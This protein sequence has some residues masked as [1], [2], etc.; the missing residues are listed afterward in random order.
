MAIPVITSLNPSSGLIGSSFNIIGTDLLNDVTL[1]QTPD[2]IWHL[3]GNLIDA[4]G[5]YTL[6]QGSVTYTTGI[7][8]QSAVLDGT[9]ALNS[10]ISVSTFR[11]GGGTNDNSISCWINLTT[12]KDFNTIWQVG[13]DVYGIL[14]GAK[15]EV[16]SSG[17]LVFTNR[18]LDN[19]TGDTTLAINTWYNIVFQS[20]TASASQSFIYINSVVDSNF[21]NFN[22]NPWGNAAGNLTFGGTNVGTNFLEGKMDEIYFFLD[23]KVTSGDASNLFNATSGTAPTIDFDGTAVTATS[24]GPTLLSGITV[25]GLTFD[26]HPVTT[27]NTDGTSNAVNFTITTGTGLDPQ[28]ML[29]WSNTK[30]HTWSN[31]HWRSMGKIGKYETRVV[32]RRLGIARNRVYEFRIT[33][34]VKIAVKGGTIEAQNMGI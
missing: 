24:S 30:G 21:N 11:G 10:N 15:L 32:W 25:P 9:Y 22:M 8:G 19:I 17:K 5:N 27:T 29:R 23:K 13:D 1:S 12:L 4:Q 18:S 33:D 6:T 31:E 16:N 7:I 34:S 2:S 26:A 3:E 20:E 14:G 28:I